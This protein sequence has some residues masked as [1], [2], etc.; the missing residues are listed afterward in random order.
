MAAS[1]AVRVPRPR[2][3]PGIP[4]RSPPERGERLPGKLPGP[5]RPRGAARCPPGSEDEGMKGRLEATRSPR[6]E[7]WAP[8]GT[9]VRGPRRFRRGRGEERRAAEEGDLQEA[10]GLTRITSLS[11][12]WQW[13]TDPCLLPETTPRPLAPARGPLGLPLRP[14]RTR[15][16]APQR[17]GGL[18]VQGGLWA[19]PWPAGGP[20][21]GLTAG[22]REGAEMGKVGAK[23][24][25]SAGGGEGRLCCFK[26]WEVGVGR[27]SPKGGRSCPDCGHQ[28]WES[29]RSLG[30]QGYAGL[31][32][33]LTVLQSLNPL[34]GPCAQPWGGPGSSFSS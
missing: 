19:L 20:A 16:Q 27:R 9:A 10:L 33:H 13:G 32:A 21:P 8:A 22:G 7:P 26:K 30:G 29:L 4:E 6:G 15:L 23:P 31:S 5:D 12:T 14:R 3:D 1:V 18:D 24:Q 17:A 34:I 25:R 11:S 28:W 2:G